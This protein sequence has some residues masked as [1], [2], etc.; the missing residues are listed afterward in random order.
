MTNEQ[1]VD[2]AC[3]SKMNDYEGVDINDEEFEDENLLQESHAID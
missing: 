2:K 3:Q 1:I